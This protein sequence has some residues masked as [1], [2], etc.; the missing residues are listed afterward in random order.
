MEAMRSFKL[1]GRGASKSAVV[2]GVFVKWLVADCSKEEREEMKEKVI[3]EKRL[4]V[5]IAAKGS[6]WFRKHLEER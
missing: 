6:A 1:S 5:A 3:D 2:V 4:R